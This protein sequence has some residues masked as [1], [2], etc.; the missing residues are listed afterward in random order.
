MA[1]AAMVC[2]MDPYRMDYVDLV[3]EMVARPSLPMASCQNV[4]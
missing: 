3:T 4:G 1:A 2:V